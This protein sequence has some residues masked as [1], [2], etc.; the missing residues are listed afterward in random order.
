MLG[1]RQANSPFP[2]EKAFAFLGHIFPPR[3]VSVKHP[4]ASK[5]HSC[6]F[7][8]VSSPFQF[9]HLQLARYLLLSC[10]LCFALRAK[11][12][13][14]CFCCLVLGVKLGHLCF[15]CLVLGA[16]LGHLCFCCLWGAVLRRTPSSSA[17]A[18][19]WLPP[20]LSR[21]SCSHQPLVLPLGTRRPGEFQTS[22]EFQLF[23]PAAVPCKRRRGLARSRPGARRGGKA[24]ARPPPSCLQPS[25]H[26]ASTLCKVPLK[27][28]KGA[29]NQN[30][31]LIPNNTVF[32]SALPAAWLF[33]AKAGRWLCWC[34]GGACV[35]RGT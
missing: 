16:K 24:E 28:P 29:R 4:T 21:A 18:A 17:E 5:F 33:G 13:H 10:D 25:C 3:E 19:I 8:R 27:P 6:L 23:H 12:G 30:P 22:L 7:Q 2:C 20:P 26:P 35:A 11:L 15:S 9:R 31:A 14:L 34:H 1:H 32:F